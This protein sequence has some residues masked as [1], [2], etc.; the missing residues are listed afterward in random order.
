[1]YVVFWFDK[2]LYSASS[3]PTP[4][5]STAILYVEHFSHRLVS[6]LTAQLCSLAFFFSVFLGPNPQHMEV[7]KL[8]VKSEP[9]P[10]LMVMLD[11]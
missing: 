7:R 10:Q 6:Y 2:V 3:P 8:G 1:M 9:T 5:L 11:P 4:I